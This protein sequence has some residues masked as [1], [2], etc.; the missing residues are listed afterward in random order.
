VSF[1]DPAQNPASKLKSL[2]RSTNVQDASSL[3]A[4]IF[5][6]ELQDHPSFKEVVPLLFKRLEGDLKLNQLFLALEPTS[7]RL[8]EQLDKHHREHFIRKA[9]GEV[10][11][12]AKVADV[13][14]KNGHKNV[15]KGEQLTP[16]TSVV[17]PDIYLPEAK[18]AFVVKNIQTTYYDRETPNLKFLTKMRILQKEASQMGVK[19]L[20]LDIYSFNA[21]V[22]SGSEKS[23][24]EASLNQ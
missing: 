11:E 2:E 22:D 12:Y 3:L 10:G 15:T 5:Q 7:M 8:P 1:S 18:V 13:F 6:M 19:V 9:Q 4:S 23:F 16:G 21:S 14:A 20:P 17:S 24:V